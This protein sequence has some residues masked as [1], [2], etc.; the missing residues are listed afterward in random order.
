MS[1]GIFVI[2]TGTDIGKTYVTGLIVK[3][4]KEI[5][6]NACYYKAAMSG[7]DR[8]EDGSLIPGDAL[9]VKNASGIEQSLE[10]MCPFIYENAYSPHLASRIEGNPV[11]LSVVMDNYNKLKEKYDYV[12]VEGSGGIMCP[13]C[14]DESKI[15]LTDIINNMELDTVLI[16]DAGLG[17]INN[18]CLTY[19]YM[20]S[21]GMKIKGIIYNNYIPSDV[22]H[23]DN[24][25]MCEYMT[26]L[27]T[28]GKV[29]KNQKD[30]DIDDETLLG[31]YN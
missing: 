7:N 5:G 12:T 6:M 1:K 8:R 26:G 25:F 4:L 27:K 2:G 29:S 24:I 16:A 17:T 10:D 18:V 22:M 13:I 14:F 21:K 9:W 20:K 30:L 28:L 11:T 3:R 15:G 31:L 23:D 19:E